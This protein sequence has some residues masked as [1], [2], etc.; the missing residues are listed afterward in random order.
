MNRS[1]KEEHAL[2]PSVEQNSMKRDGDALFIT[3]AQDTNFQV[4]KSTDR[5]PA[6]CLGI[7]GR[8]VDLRDPIHVRETGGPVGKVHWVPARPWSLWNAHLRKRPLSCRQ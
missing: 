2:A 5:W 7:S 8:C 4:D 1:L 6:L 3:A